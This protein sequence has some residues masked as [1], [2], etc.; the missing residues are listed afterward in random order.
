MAAATWTP[1]HG[2]RPAPG[3]H[4]ATLHDCASDFAADGTVRHD[5]PVLVTSV[6]TCTVGVRV[7][8]VRCDG[9]LIEWIQEGAS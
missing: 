8:G 6:D 3:D 7:R 9:S 4:V 1:M 5:V 2:G